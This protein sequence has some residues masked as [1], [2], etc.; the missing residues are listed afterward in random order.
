MVYHRGVKTARPWNITLL[1]MRLTHISNLYSLTH[2]WRKLLPATSCYGTNALIQL[3]QLRCQTVAGE[4]WGDLKPKAGLVCATPH[5]QVAFNNFHQ[6]KRSTQK[7]VASRI[8]N[9]SCL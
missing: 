8:Y 5:M 3:L 9:L 7:P 6:M 4:V 2:F 1:R